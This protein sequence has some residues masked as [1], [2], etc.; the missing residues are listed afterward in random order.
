MNFLAIVPKLMG[1]MTPFEP[2]D[3]PLGIAYISAVLKKEGHNVWGL[4]LNHYFYLDD[5]GLRKVIGRTIK[6][7]AID[8]VCIGG[9]SAHYKQIKMIIDSVCFT[10]PGIITVLGGGIISSNP[11]LVYESLDVDYGV[12]GEGEL[13]ILELAKC[14][15]DGRNL[16]GVCGVVYR[17]AKGKAVVT[18]P[19]EPIEDLDS[20]P[21]PDY[22]TFNIDHYL[23]LQV[24]MGYLIRSMFI[25]DNPRMMGIA[26]SRSCPF[27]C[28]FC[29]HPLGRK[30]RQRTMD[31]VFKEIDYLVNRYQINTLGII[32]ELFSYNPERVKEF[33]ARI[34]KYGISWM[35][36]LRVSDVNEEMLEMM[37]DSGCY[38]I[39]YGLESMSQEV[40]NSMKKRITRE[41]IE[42]ALELTYK[43]QINIQ[44]NFIF[45]DRAETLQSVRET[46]EWWIKNRK[47]RVNLSHVIAFPGTELYRYA[48]ETGRIKNEVKF[49]EDGCPYI[50]LTQMNEKEHQKMLS[51]IWEHQRKYLMPARIESIRVGEIHP[52]IGE[53]YRVRFECAHCN[54]I[55]EY[56]RL[57][58]LRDLKQPKLNV[59]GCR[60]CGCNSDLIMPPLE[61]L[62]YYYDFFGED[63]TVQE[64]E[65]V[66]QPFLSALEPQRQG[67][68]HILPVQCRY[69][70][71]K[72]CCVVI[73]LNESENA[74]AFYEIP[75][76]IRN[77]E[78]KELSSEKIRLDPL[79]VSPDSPMLWVFY[80]E[81][82]ELSIGN[83]GQPDCQDFVLG[84]RGDEIAYQILN[85]K[86]NTNL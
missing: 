44:G 22:E 63:Y 26:T 43:M 15:T 30:Y 69:V 18:E 31:H 52:L 53:T 77:Q 11:K 62:V 17:D 20:L 38:Q 2:Y 6:E 76:L 75:I 47:Y 79:V 73:I 78:G 9:L 46:L 70:N 86:V 67:K 49:L 60:H 57:K 68:I 82:N 55:N 37:K 45:G 72:F 41:Q 12:V 39:S 36:Q 24:P 61:K 54:K 74:I 59:V 16:E 21:L 10:S 71:G 64:I 34:K 40:L 65:T 35:C 3:F 81:P 13:T 14:L 84:V 32:D 85:W 66:L 48:V 25:R 80:Y 83:G 28:T 58:L 42:K 29:F 7:N 23:T 27:N 33:C 5:T 51:L 50:N 56:K 8:A 19:R 4:D 1:R